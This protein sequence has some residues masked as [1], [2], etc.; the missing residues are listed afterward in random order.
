MQDDVAV[1]TGGSSGIGRACVEAL[2]AEG[3]Q[4]ATCGRD[5]EQLDRALAPLAE[6]YPDRLA[7]WPADVRDRALVDRLIDNTVDR[8]GGLQY[9]VN[10]A[11]ASRVS[12]FA[13]TEDHEWIDEVGLKFFGVIHPVRAALPH[14]AARGG[15]VVNLNAVLARQPEPH[16][17]ATGAARA[18]LL[19]LSK[20]LAHELAD[21][22]VRVNSVCVGLID[23][24]QWK[25][26]FDAADSD[27]DFPAW[28]AE[29]AEDRG[30]DLGRFGTAAEVA[31]AIVFLLSPRSSYTTGTALDISGGV[32]RYV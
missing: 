23:T 2:L 19:N 29:I 18:G 15:A 31:A 14:L 28:S 13:T 9:L 4:V 6:R 7:W 30:I 10:N 22:R 5:A 27:L 26:R 32:S 3:V 24:G 20:S 25:R 11:G 21:Q 1:V 16:L 12:T 8:F 17:I